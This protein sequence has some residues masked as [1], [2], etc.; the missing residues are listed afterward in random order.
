MIGDQAANSKNVV[1]VIPT[2]QL[3]AVFEFILLTRLSVEQFAM[4]RFD[5]RFAHLDH[6]EPPPVKQI[7]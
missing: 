1:L 2:L 6:R 7:F 3:I 4:L 5:D